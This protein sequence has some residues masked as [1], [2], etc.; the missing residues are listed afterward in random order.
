MPRHLV[1]AARV[2]RRSP[3]FAISIFK[4]AHSLKKGTSLGDTASRAG[5]AKMRDAEQTIAA[6]SA[7]KHNRQTLSAKAPAQGRNKI[8]GYATAATARS[9]TAL[10]PKTRLRW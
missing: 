7:S 5:L 8:N 2:C 3:R 10:Q 6:G 9:S 4:H 1:A